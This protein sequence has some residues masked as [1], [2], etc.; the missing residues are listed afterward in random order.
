MFE[1]PLLQ[2]MVCSQYVSLDE[3]IHQCRITH[4]CA[5]PCPLEDCFNQASLGR[6]AARAD[7]AGAGSCMD[8]PT[9]GAVRRT[10]GRRY[11]VPF[12]VDWCDEIDAAGAVR[13]ECFQP[14]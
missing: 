6:A 9:G 4:D 14:S 13:L 5:S 12:S 8:A 7:R 3:S 1:P 2:C 10:L 11:D